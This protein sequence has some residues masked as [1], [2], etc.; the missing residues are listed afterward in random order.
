MHY[1]IKGKHCETK[2]LYRTAYCSAEPARIRDYLNRPA[3]HNRNS[4][5]DNCQLFEWLC[6]VFGALGI[7][8]RDILASQACQTVRDFTG[9]LANSRLRCHGYVVCHVRAKRAYRGF[10]SAFAFGCQYPLV[11]LYP[12]GCNGERA[13]S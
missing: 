8:R 13:K 1:S 9:K 10:H 12:F 5:L 7:L 3:Y 11:Y 4:W 6:L 2:P